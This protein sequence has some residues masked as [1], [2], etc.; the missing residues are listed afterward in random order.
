MWIDGSTCTATVLNDETSSILLR[1]W[2]PWI[3]NYNDMILFLF[4][5]N[6]DI[7]FIGSGEVAKALTYY[8]TDYI[9]KA[10]LPTHLGLQALCYAI[11]SNNTKFASA[12]PETLLSSVEV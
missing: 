4:K 6:I 1:Q 11:K 3:N 5:C 8:I 9:T 10:S 12:L 2:H 7:K